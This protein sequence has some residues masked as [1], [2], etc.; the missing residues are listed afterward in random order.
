MGNANICG[1]TRMDCLRGDMTIKPLE[2]D[3]RP[4]LKL[5]EVQKTA[6]VDLPQ[7]IHCLMKKNQ[8]V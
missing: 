3:E 2:K 7:G 6:M 1:D 4:H 5:Q 8:R